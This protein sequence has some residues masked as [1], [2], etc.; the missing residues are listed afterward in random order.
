MRIDWQRVEFFFQ[1][2][3]FRIS[4]LLFFC[5]FIGVFVYAYHTETQIEPVGQ[6]APFPTQVAV[7]DESIEEDA[8]SKPHRTRREMQVWI[9]DATSELLNIDSSMQDILM[10]EARPY[11]NDKGY[12]QYQAYLNKDGRRKKIAEGALRLS[13]IVDE[14][15]VLLNEGLISGQYRW[16]YD[17]PVLITEDPRTGDPVNTKAT[18]RLQVGRVDDSVNA[19]K[20]VIES[21]AMLPRR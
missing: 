15:P 7:I 13:A 21:W 20:M 11:F 6:N 4:F 9:I 2:V 19:Q 8:V 1:T 3:F 18:L 14:A 17:V 10:A 12:R 16:L 5:L